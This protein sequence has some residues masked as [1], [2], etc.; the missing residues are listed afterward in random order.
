MK[1][2][3]LVLVFLSEEHRALVS[4]RFEVIY[5]P[6]EKL[7]AD[8]TNGEA[9]I[10]ARGPDIRVVLTNGTNGLLASE[11]A[12]LPKLELISTVGVGFENIALDAASTRG[13]PVCN[14]A[15]T[16]DAAVADHAMAIL[17]AAIRRLPFLNDGV[18]NGLWRDDIPRPPHVSGR[19][20]GI[21]GLGAIGRKIAKRASGFDMEIGY[22]SRT[23]RDETGFQWFD[24]ILSLA[25]WCDFLVI[26]APGGKA[27]F[28]IVDREVL[29]ALGPQGVLVNIARGT[30][31]DTNAV[32]D[33]LREKRIWAAALDVYENEP[34][35]PAQ[36]LA[37]D[38]AVLTPHVGG[39]SPQAIHASVLRFL[40][41]AEAHFAG[42]PL[43]TRVN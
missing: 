36:L 8:R 14:A 43:V 24:G 17:L 15:G 27:T 35:P 41:N 2:L 22:H 34:A 40:E 23:R 39:I 3:L 21:F 18:R 28:H 42:R 1:P 7:G 19:R 13:I 6:N 32:A 33:A 10:A 4:E 11:I 38:N 37:F 29:D 25:A 26:A 16:N 31:V 20:M 30:L 9:Q 5:S 12:A